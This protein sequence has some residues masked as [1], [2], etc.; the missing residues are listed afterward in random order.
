[1]V[2]YFLTV[3]D[4]SKNSL[5]EE[6]AQNPVVDATKMY[7][8]KGR[9]GPA[10]FTALMDIRLGD[11]TVHAKG[12]FARLIIK[13]AMRA[14][15]HLTMMKAIIDAL[16][17]EAQLTCSLPHSWKT[18]TTINLLYRNKTFGSKRSI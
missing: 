13:V 7:F 10:E 6:V 4:K 3:A 18:R 5:L 9:K 17:M 16:L 2:E 12:V 11:T 15:M 8:L 1:M 14:V